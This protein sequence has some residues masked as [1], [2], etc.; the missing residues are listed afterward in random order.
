MS[1]LPR[2]RRRPR[3]AVSL[4]QAHMSFLPAGSSMSAI[5]RS[6]NRV[7]I[8][9]L[10]LGGCWEGHPARASWHTAN[11]AP[12]ARQIKPSNGIQG[13]YRPIPLSGVKRKASK[14]CP[15]NAGFLLAVPGLGGRWE[16]EGAAGE[17]KAHLGKGGTRPQISDSQSP[18]NVGEWR[19]NGGQHG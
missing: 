5:E 12:I 11:I 6:V 2:R 17:Y 4:S 14:K 16:E 9:A 15:Q 1:V 7:F 19:S 3:P 10:R 18:Q 13:N 8:S